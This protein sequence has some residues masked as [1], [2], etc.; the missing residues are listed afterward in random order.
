MLL[1]LFANSVLPSCFWPQYRVA[2][3]SDLQDYSWVDYGSITDKTFKSTGVLSHNG[4]LTVAM[5]TLECLLPL[6]PSGN[7]HIN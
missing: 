3:Q 5:H 1:L 2:T 4:K 7:D 6:T